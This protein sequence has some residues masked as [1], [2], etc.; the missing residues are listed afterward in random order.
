MPYDQMSDLTVNLRSKAASGAVHLMG[1][2]VAAITRDLIKVTVF[3]DLQ[4]AS[5]KK[6]SCVKVRLTAQCVL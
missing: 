5:Y 4:D 3:I 1:N 2:L 6:K